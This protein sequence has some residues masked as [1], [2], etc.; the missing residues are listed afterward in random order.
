MGKEYKRHHEEPDEINRF[1]EL[2]PFQRGRKETVTVLF[3]L[4]GSSMAELGSFGW[5]DQPAWAT[6][7]MLPKNAYGLFPLRFSFTV[8]T[9][10]AGQL[11][12]TVEETIRVEIEGRPT[13]F[14][15]ISVSL[16]EEEQKQQPINTKAVAL[17]GGAVLALAVGIG[18]IAESK[19][20]QASAAVPTS[21]P[22]PTHTLTP[23]EIPTE[24][25]T[26]VPVK[27]DNPVI[28]KLSGKSSYP[29]P[30]YMDNPA[31]SSDSTKVATLDGDGNLIIK[32]PSGRIVGSFQNSGFVS[33]SPDGNKLVTTSYDQ[34]AKESKIIV[35]DINGANLKVLKSYNWEKP[36]SF[37]SWSP[38]G[39]FIVLSDYGIATSHHDHDIII[40]DVNGNYVRTI[41][42]GHHAVWAPSGK[43]II[44]ETYRSDIDAFY[45]ISIVQPD[46]QRNI[47]INGQWYIWNAIWDSTGN[48]VVIDTGNEAGQEDWQIDFPNE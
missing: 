17:F 24:I 31:T 36:Y 13:H 1:V 47:Q 6:K 35:S 39:K 19:N 12:E 43:W 27:I 15:N 3:D 8:D 34:D 42:T 26:K 40:L 11:G 48:S 21:T 23:T 20:G 44:Y 32:D 38:D 29:R 14:I 46:G 7:V 33:F 37:A 5:V 9:T 22:S 28:T 41:A 45:F 10:I 16:Q 30:N 25:H 18:L 4:H 2:G